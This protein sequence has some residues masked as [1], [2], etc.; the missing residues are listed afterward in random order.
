MRCFVTTMLQGGPSCPGPGLGWIQFWLFH[1]AL[2]YLEWW[3]LGR[4]GQAAGQDGWNILIKVN[5]TQVPDQVAHPALLAIWKLFNLWKVT[6]SQARP[7]MTVLKHSLAFPVF[8]DYFFSLGLISERRINL[9]FSHLTAHPTLLS[10]CAHSSFCSAHKLLNFHF[11]L[12]GHPYMTSALRGVAK[13]RCS[14]GGCV[15]LVL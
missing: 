10:S 6:G 13:R 14:K 4:M 1:C 2:F 12:R 9:G 5:P 7:L 8:L 11:S 15:N 3:D